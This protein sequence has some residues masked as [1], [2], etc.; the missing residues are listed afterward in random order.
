MTSERAWSTNALWS[1]KSMVTSGGAGDGLGCSKVVVS[2][3]ADAESTVC[4]T[5]WSTSSGAGATAGISHRSAGSNSAG[6]RG[7]CAQSVRAHG[8]AAG[9]VSQQR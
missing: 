9:L 8:G 6:R 4:G 5:G 2:A 1:P 7:R 3:A